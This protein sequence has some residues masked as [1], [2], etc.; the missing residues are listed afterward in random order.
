LYV[1][2][3]GKGYSDNAERFVFFLKTI[4]LIIN[5]LNWV[6]DVIQANDWHTGL[7]SIEIKNYF[8]NGFN[9]KIVFSIH[10]MAYQGIFSLEVSKK[11]GFN[12][13]P[14]FKDLI[15]QNKLNFLKTGIKT[16]DFLITV[17]KNYRNE[18]LTPEYGYGLEKYLI[19]R[20]ESF[21]GILNGVDYSEWNPEDD[22]LIP[23]KYSNLDL[24]GKIICKEKLL[25]EQKL[26]KK[27]GVPLIGM[28][29]RL[30]YQKG[31]DITLE[32]LKSLLN[33]FN[34]QIV[35]VGKGNPKYEEELK[36]LANEFPEK[37]VVNIVFNNKLSHQVE[38]GSDFFLM[39]SRYE[40]C[41]LNQM[42]SL[43][44]GTFP[45]V[46]SI[47]GLADTIIDLTKFPA[48]GNGFSFLPYEAEA[49]SE[50]II[51]ALD[52]YQTKSKDKLN[53]IRSRIMQEDFSWGKSAKEYNNI[54]QKITS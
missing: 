46:R 13:Q 29:T 12:K 35:I 30:G 45:I 39:P 31:I 28:V 15:H 14:F 7:L 11:L 1:D 9:P 6:P 25:E 51:R 20:Q 47:G 34:F 49:L 19:E 27:D 38:A 2:E 8:N 36:L 3:R 48:E 18:V 24:S 23:A 42:Y 10:N 33:N 53:E 41:G 50:T 17:S 21:V 44:Y 52:F 40:P 37:L 16:S 26:Y 4:P 32:S 22:L 5:H 54:Y 43:R